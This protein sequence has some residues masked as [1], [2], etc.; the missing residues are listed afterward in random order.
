M[1]SD[2]NEGAASGS[3]MSYAEP[4]IERLTRPLDR[5]N[6][7]IRGELVALLLG[8][9]ELIW[10]GAACLASLALAYTALVSGATGMALCV[11]CAAAIAFRTLTLRKRASGDD[12]VTPFLI[13]GLVYAG[14]IGMVGFACAASREPPVVLLG[15]LVLTGIGFGVAFANAGAPLFARLQ[16]VLISAPYIV[17]TALSDD[18][19]M[20]VVAFQAPLWI[21]GIFAI[22]RSTHDLSARLI[23]AQKRSSYLAFHDVLTGL[24]NRARLLEALRAM[25]SSK[26]PGA[27]LLYL[28]LDGFKRVND[29]F[30]HMAGDEL[31]RLM[32]LRIKSALRPDDIVS[33]I[34]GDEFVVILQ[35]LDLDGVERVAFRLIEAARAPFPIGESKASIG[36]SVGGAPIDVGADPD[37]AIAAADAMLYAAKKAGKGQARLAA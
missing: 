7:D 8:R 22:V 1:E 5:A 13:S 18:R 28:D 23:R 3:G 30:G 25:R 26:A 21:A 12:A 24:G 31:L 9:P 34:G 33:R 35:D 20:L 15:G 27:Y 29:T 19:T 16:I 37:R 11:A 10:F 36:L 14:V 6:E 4:L 17:A 32:A 2:L